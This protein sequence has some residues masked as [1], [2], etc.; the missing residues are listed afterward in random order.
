[1]QEWLQSIVASQIHPALSPLP[2]LS[3]EG[4]R[5]TSG[6]ERRST[7]EK[8]CPRGQRGIPMGLPAA[9]NIVGIH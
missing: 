5:S 3:P 8:K 2:R 6:Q 9:Q 4:L 1:M 7:A